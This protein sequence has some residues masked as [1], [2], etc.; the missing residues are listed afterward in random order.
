MDFEADIENMIWRLEAK[1]ER[2]TNF[3]IHF[4]DGLR[5]ERKA[6]SMNPNSFYLLLK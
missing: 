1:N 3:K 4:K 2:N 5:S 6:L